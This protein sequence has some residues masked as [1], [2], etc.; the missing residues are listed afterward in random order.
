MKKTKRLA[1]LVT[2]ILLMAGL[3]GCTYGFP[4]GYDKDTVT[5]KAEEM[6]ELV[7]TLD[8]EAIAAAL[9]EDMQER[10]TAEDF[11]NAWGKKLTKLGGFKKFGT[12]VLSG[13]MDTDTGEEFAL[14]AYKCYYENGSATFTVYFDSNME[15][16]A[17]YLK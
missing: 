13:E 10:V 6:I 17:I 12:P 7:N 16:T 9:R 15:M 2:V 11:E 3:F 1:K 14:V 5:D 8:Y 4:E